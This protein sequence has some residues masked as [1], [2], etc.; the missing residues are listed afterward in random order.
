[1]HAKKEQKIY[2]NLIKREASI[3]YNDI[4]DMAGICQL[5]SSAQTF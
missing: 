4:D 1:M 3:S 5:Y 2:V